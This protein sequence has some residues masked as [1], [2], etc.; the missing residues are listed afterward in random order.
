MSE[1]E[2][3]MSEKA[4]YELATSCNKKFVVGISRNNKYKDKYEAK[5]WNTQDMC[6]IS[7]F[8]VIVELGGM[9]YAIS[10][11]GAY[12]ATAKF[13]DF[14][15][16][17]VFL[18]SVKSGKVVLGT[19]S[20][21][22]VQWLMFEDNNV[23][24]VGTENA[25]IFSLD[26]LKG[27]CTTLCKGKRICVNKWGE[28]IVLLNKR[29]AKCGNQVFAASTFSYL[30][31]AGTPR[32]ILLSEINGD[33]FYYGYE[34]DLYWKTELLDLGHFI[35]VCYDEKKNR[36]YG[37]L[38]NPKK[39][40]IDRMHLVIFE[41]NNPFPIYVRSIEVSNY[42]FAGGIK[43]IMLINGKGDTY[44]INDEIEKTYSLF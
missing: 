37:I 6:E 29:K 35:S 16:E 30:C 39:K 38:F 15:N 2:R 7:K 22:K 31:I 13:S 25:G 41:E 26:V 27:S 8:D 21:K 5:I 14:R 44:I 33:L 24:L 10:N 1:E 9:R 19:A 3:R 40:Q 20:F 11:D 34:G 32:G 43:G 28:A 18:Y 17:S 36:I 42:V 12:I 23:L 4:I